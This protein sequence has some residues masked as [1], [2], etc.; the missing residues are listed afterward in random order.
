MTRSLAHFRR[1]AVPLLKKFKLNAG[2]KVIKSLHNSFMACEKL[3]GVPC[4][5]E[6]VR[7]K[8]RQSFHPLHLHRLEA[9]QARR[10]RSGLHEEYDV[11]KSIHILAVPRYPDRGSMSRMTPA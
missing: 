9:A 3:L 1:A 8:K 4:D 10:K 6:I 5:I 11:P 2:P 7:D